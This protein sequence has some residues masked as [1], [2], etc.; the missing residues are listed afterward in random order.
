MRLQYRCLNVKDRSGN[1]VLRSDI[2][3]RDR[4]FFNTSADKISQNGDIVKLPVTETEPCEGADGDG[5]SHADHVTEQTHGKPLPCPPYPVRCYVATP[6][7]SSW[8]NF[9]VRPKTLP[10]TSAPSTRVAGGQ[11]L[12]GAWGRRGQGRCRHPLT[13]CAT[14]YMPRTARGGHLRR[15]RAFRCRGR[16]IRDTASVS[17]PVRGEKLSREGTLGFSTV[18]ANTSKEILSYETLPC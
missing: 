8:G 18:P 12:A 9:P 4:P 17:L 3:G 2:S 10:V 13:T 7:P 11:P 6:S 14:C 15:H 16:V 5:P 1:V